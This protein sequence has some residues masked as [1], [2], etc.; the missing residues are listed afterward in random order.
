M[1]TGVLAHG[2][3]IKAKGWDDIL[4]GNPDQ[5]RLGRLPRAVLAILDADP[6]TIGLVTI[7]TGASRSE[8]GTFEA[9]LVK[10]LALQRFGQLDNFTAIRDHPEWPKN[11]SHIQ[12]LLEASITDTASKNTHQEIGNAATLFSKRKINRVFEVTDPS[13]G[14]R[15]QRDQGVARA[16][17]LIP[18]SQRWH[19]VTSNVP[20]PGTTVE[21]TVVFEV[22]H[23]GDDPAI[24]WP[25][26]KQASRVF[27]QYFSMSNEDKIGF[28]N[29]V[30]DLAKQWL[31][32]AIK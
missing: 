10:H 21:D 1:N 28:L 12:S 29:D 25:K 7:G 3:H 17:G 15:C 30:D 14:P 4:W 8:N 9:E 31:H 6:R 23:R 13:H 18:P 22:P 16:S 5:Q 26:D 27:S 20:Y 2:L 11:G 24:A 32:R 19:L